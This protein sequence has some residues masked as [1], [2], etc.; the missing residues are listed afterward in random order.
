MTNT[1]NYNLNIVQGSDLVNP[2]IQTNPNFETID[3]AMKANADRGVQLATELKS[4]TVHRITRTNPTAPVFYFVATT[5][6]VAGETFT[7]DSVQCT[8]YTT[9]GQPLTTNAYRIGAK[10]IGIITGTVIT[11]LVSSGQ[12]AIAS[13][14]E[15]LGGQL[16]AY[17]A[18]AAGLAATDQT[19]TAA[20]T[21]AGNAIP[22]GDV[23]AILKVTEL[24]AEPVATV[25]YCVVEQ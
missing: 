7:V 1:T 11:F 13:D 16:P 3:S 17:Y 5:D 18:T 10:V 4:G 20:A 22:K 23:T 24:P 21:L 25:M 6:Y 2:L 15:R 12:A 8:A 9:D 14:S 19:A